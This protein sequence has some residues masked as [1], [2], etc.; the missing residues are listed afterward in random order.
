[1]NTCPSLAQI[2]THLPLPGSPQDISC[3]DVNVELRSPAEASA[4]ETEPEQS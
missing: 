4:N 2:V 3:P 1:M